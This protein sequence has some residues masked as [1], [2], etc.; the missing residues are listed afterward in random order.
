MAR[1]STPQ[2]LTHAAVFK[3]SCPLGLRLP[4]ATP[5]DNPSVQ[6]PGLRGCSGARERVGTQPA[7]PGKHTHTHNCEGTCRHTHAHARAFARAR[8]SAG[9]P[10]MLKQAIIQTILPWPEFQNR[11]ARNLGN[12]CQAQPLCHR[13][14]ENVRTNTQR[15]RS[16]SGVSGAP[17]TACS[18]IT[19][20][21]QWAT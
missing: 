17:K 8:A 13:H 16:D 3:L 18:D 10:S 15:S 20:L 2:T 14:A 1:S 7:H 5:L 21:K 11:C 12:H 4:R 6:P 9:A 19:T